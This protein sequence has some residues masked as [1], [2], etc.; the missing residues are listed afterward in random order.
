MYERILICHDG[1]ELSK[2]GAEKAVRLA[3]KC[4]AKLYGLYISSF[5]P[6]ITP[7]LM[8]SIDEILHSQEEFMEKEFSKMREDC[9]KEGIEFEYLIRRGPV[10]PTV[11]EIVE[12][13]DVDLIVVGAKKHRGLTEFFVGSFSSTIF[14]GIT[15]DL[16]VVRT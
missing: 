5:T 12:K 11:S 7:D 4:G 9:K 8:I 2:L 10:L 13:F 14:H 6:I 15:R 3:K 1:S 16:L